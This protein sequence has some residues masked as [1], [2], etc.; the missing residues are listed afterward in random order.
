LS[1]RRMRRCDYARAKCNKKFTAIVHAAP[2]LG[3]QYARIC[4]RQQTSKSNSA[5]RLRGVD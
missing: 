1:E 3:A 5:E 4:D 2:S